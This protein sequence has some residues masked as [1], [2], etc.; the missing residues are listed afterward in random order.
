MYRKSNKGWAKHTDFLIIDMLSLELA[1]FLAYW[2][3]HGFNSNLVV[4]NS[5]F[6]MIFVLVMVDFISMALL[7]TFSGV[8]RRGYLVEII[9]TIKQAFLVMILSAFYLFSVQE[10]DDYSRITLVLTGV[11]YATFAFISRCLWKKYLHQ[12][13]NSALRSMIVISSESEVRRMIANFKEHN[14]S[15]IG[16]TGI[17]IIDCSRIGSKID[18]IEIVAD[19][20]T[21]EEYVLNNWV[22]EALFGM[23]LDRELSYRLQ[24]TFLE[25][26]ITTHQSLLEVK[27][28]SEIERNIERIGGYTVITRSIRI[29]TTEELVMKRTMDILGGIVGC[30]ITAI[31]C[32]FVG[33]A[34]YLTSPGPIFFSQDRIGKNGRIF[35]MHKFR[36][37]YLDAEDRLKELKDQNERDDDF[38]FKMENDPRIIGSEKGPGKGIGNFIRKTSIDEFPQFWNVLIGEMSLVGTRPPLVSEWEQYENHHRARMATKPGITG[39][40][41]VSGRSDIKDFEE[42]V[43]LDME[44]I[45]NWSFALD[46]KILIKTLKQVLEH[47]GAM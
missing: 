47:K 29:L 42:V 40:W 12:K 7:R 33:P 14:Y 20:D 11:L 43:D 45:E 41:Q 31:L 46:V 26:G 28:E 18:G 10:G 13:K 21:I 1:F 22:D 35:R 8:L 38:M 30:L 3:R 9:A 6:H 32:I 15:N 19:K 36:S 5:Y 44:Y 23:T 37:M 17:A 16:I 39:M 27:N 24:R 34:I 25:M 2:I 4:R